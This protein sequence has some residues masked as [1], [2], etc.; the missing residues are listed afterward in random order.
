MLEPTGDSGQ[1]LKIE[2]GLGRLRLQKGKHVIVG[3]MMISVRPIDIG[4]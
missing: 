1:Y 3:W 4:S 2:D